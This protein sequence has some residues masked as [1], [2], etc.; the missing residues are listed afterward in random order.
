M[1]HNQLSEPQQAAVFL[2]SLFLPTR[3]FLISLDFSWFL[4]FSVQPFL[5]F[6]PNQSGNFIFNLDGQS[7]KDKGVHTVWSMSGYVF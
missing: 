1:N 3:C 6:S 4:S 2:V 5:E 7:L